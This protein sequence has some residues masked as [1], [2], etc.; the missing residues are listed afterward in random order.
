MQ[1]IKKAGENL[2]PIR[3]FGRVVRSKFGFK[4]KKMHYV[5]YKSYISKLR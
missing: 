5:V 1:L 2:T 3:A 4:E